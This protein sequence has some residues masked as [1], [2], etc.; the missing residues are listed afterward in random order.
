MD[1]SGLCVSPGARGVSVPHHLHGGGV[2]EGH[3][4]RPALPPQRLPEERLESARLHHRGSRVSTHTHTPVEF[5]RRKDND[6][7]SLG[8]RIHRL[9][10]KKYILKHHHVAG[11]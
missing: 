3:S 6:G 2:P 9:F 8:V 5:D 4:L 10:C 1:L 7:E 11:E